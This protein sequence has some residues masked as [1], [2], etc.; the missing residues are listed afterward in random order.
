MEVVVEGPETELVEKIKRARGKDE[1]VVKFV[2]EMKNAGVKILKRDEWEIEGELV[3]KKRKR[4]MPKNKELQLEV[5]W[6]HHDVPVAGHEGRWKTTE[7]VMRNYL[8]PKMTKD[9][10]RYVEGCG[11]YQRMKNQTEAPTGKLVMNKVPKKSVFL[12]CKTCSCPEEK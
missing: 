7:L 10:G 11:L 2:E 4:Y 6:L 9:M 8:W 5:I 3:L 1:E 12:H